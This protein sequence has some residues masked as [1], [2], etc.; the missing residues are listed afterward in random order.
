MPL[1]T[2]SA[3]LLCQSPLSSS[4]CRDKEKSFC[5]AGCQA[6]YQILESRQVLEKAHDHPLFQQALRS[7]LIAN[8]G[9]L[10]QINQKKEAFSHEEK[11]KIPLEI[12]DMWC[13]SCAQVIRLTLLK[14]EGVKECHVDYTTD[15]ASIEYIPRLMSKEKILKLVRQLG[16]VPVLMTDPRQQTNHRRLSLRFIVAA[17]FSM[18]VMMFAYPIYAGYFY[19]DTEGYAR[20][21]AWLS[22]AGSLPVLLYS[23]WPIW[24][25]FYSAM[26]VGIWGMETL[27]AL[28]V[29]SATALSLYELTQDSL[30]VY[31][32]SMTVIIVFVL[33]GKM[34]EGRAKFS[35]KDALVQLTRALPRRGR[36]RFST[37]EEKF[38]PIKD[39]NVGDL[40]VVFCG[41]K[42]VLDGEV[43]E[44]EGS[45]DESLM[46]GESLPAHKTRGASVLAGTI[47][48]Q[49]HLTVKVKAD[50]EGSALYH[51]V[52]MVERDVGHK[53]AYTRAIDP[54][55]RWFVPAVGL[56]AFAVF[57][58]CLIF[59][60]MDGEKTPFQTGIIRAVSVLLIS[61]PCAI[62]I[63]APLA[64]SHL[65]N[66]LA[67]LGVI[68][69][70]RGCLP[71]IGRE[72]TFICDKTGTITEGKYSV[73][74]GL[75]TLS[76]QNK[77]ILKEMVSKSSHPVAIAIN[78]ELLCI[79]EPLEKV[80]EIIGRGIKAEKLATHYILGS[81]IFLAQQGIEA[82]PL[83]ELQNEINT[84]VYFGWNNQCMALIYLGDS[85]RPEAKELVKE[86]SDTR[87]VLLS[88]D[89]LITV[90]AAANAC[91]FS[92]WHGEFHPL[93]KRNFIDALKQKGEI[94][95]MLGDGVNDAPALT[96]AN[97]GIAVVSATDISIQ[98]SDLLL[99]TDR[100]LIIPMLRKLAKKGHSILKQNIF[101]SFFYNCIGLGLAASG[102]LTPLFAA[103]AMVASSLIVVLN[104]QRLRK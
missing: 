3:C 66:A 87:S 104:T 70:N 21:F 19:E 69:R 82:V 57:A 31:F 26:R 51:I 30:Y 35:A 25:R 43:L 62:G 81:S 29:A 49:G 90:E 89:A 46:T 13:P 15:L 52:E 1:S 59:N 64:E 56:L 33:L 94:V 42:I 83:P 12:H 86:L 92:A 76:F 84:V 11:E 32:D 73:L 63:A 27:V 44:G 100:L 45:C 17:F 4:Y 72:T 67:K 50:S 18:N 78:K 8:P 5:C 68:V 101:W 85:I 55:I 58:S 77:R 88:G 79:G 40:L 71:Y 37:G 23:A 16:Y 7:G 99:T 61:C 41:E 102:A 54:I 74:K 93:Q 60:I 98:V 80:E 24:R 97:V 53:S 38:V 65:L 91:G 36:K 47:L 6:V 48:Q 20:L 39:F 103:F 28:G 9:L 14:E 95:A 22:F 96:A 75:E 34:I 2:S 10:E